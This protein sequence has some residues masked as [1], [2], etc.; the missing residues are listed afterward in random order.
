MR[1]VSGGKARGKAPVR[2]RPRPRWLARLLRL[3]LPAL[4]LLLLAGGGAWL[5]RSGWVG[6]K[7]AAGEAALLT[8]SGRA[9]LVLNDIEI[10]GRTQ[11][12]QPAVMAAL[13]LRRGIPLL[14]VSPEALRERLEALPWV[15]AATVERRL[16]DRLYVRLEESQPLA[17]WQH[18]G[19]FSLIGAGGEVIEEPDVGRFNHLLQVVGED[20]PAHAA[21]LI[22]MLG[23]EPDLQ[24]RVTAAVLVS[25]RR[26]NL[27]LDNGIDVRLPEENSA[28]AWTRLA[29]LD[30]QRKLL[31]KDLVSIDLRDPD[32]L[33]VRLSPAAAAK[34]R[35]VTP[36]K[37][38][39]NT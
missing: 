29:E 18:D 5:W 4:A 28:A 3:G 17:L 22:A 35:V 9:G 1:R 8:A 12:T 23:R 30:R 38:G 27:H 34:R 13:K 16:P 26:W 31:D 11:T 20:A 15:K 36:A 25:G 21:K 7:L 19:R 24:Q 37:P 2:R 39:S 14:A 6:E 32:R 33:V 10:A